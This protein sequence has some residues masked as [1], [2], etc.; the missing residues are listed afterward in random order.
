M[1]GEQNEL[2]VVL[3]NTYRR[4]FD[5]MLAMSSHS[6]YACMH[7]CS[8]YLGHPQVN[9]SF[10]RAKPSCTACRTIMC[11]DR[12]SSQFAVMAAYIGRGLHIRQTGLQNSSMDWPELR[13]AMLRLEV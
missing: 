7:A 9:N 12:D 13:H 4:L 11:A 1:N 10:S 2:D 5:H 6:A 8:L 3:V